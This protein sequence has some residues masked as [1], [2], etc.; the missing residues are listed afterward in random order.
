[1]NGMQNDMQMFENII[2]F[3]EIQTSTDSQESIFP[4][5]P[6]FNF[7]PELSLEIALLLKRVPSVTCKNFIQ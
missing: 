1:M 3:A 6:E 4:L 2:Y 5:C 7:W